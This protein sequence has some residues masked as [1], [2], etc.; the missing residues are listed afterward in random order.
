[1]RPIIGLAVA[2]LASYVGLI[3]WWSRPWRLDRGAPYGRLPRSWR[4]YGRQ[5]LDEAGR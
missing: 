2:V 5:S 4:P 1:M 3:A